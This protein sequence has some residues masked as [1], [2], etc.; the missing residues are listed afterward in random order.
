MPAVIAS[1]FAVSGAND[2]VTMSNID[3]SDINRG[4][5]SMAPVVD[6]EGYESIIEQTCE[7]LSKSD[8]AS[9][10]RVSNELPL[11]SMPSTRRMTPETFYRSCFKTTA[12]FNSSRS[13]TWQANTPPDDN[14]VSDITYSHQ[15]NRLP[16]LLRRLRPIP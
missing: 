15:K 4:F 2:Y 11:A 5:A 13:S 10:M 1:N 6:L 7:D 16:N 12:S 3:G 9:P 14:N 8:L